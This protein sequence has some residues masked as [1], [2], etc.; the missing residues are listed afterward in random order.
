MHHVLFFSTSKHSSSDGD[1][2]SWLAD[3]VDDFAFL[4]ALGAPYWLHQDHTAE[5]RCQ[6]DSN[7]ETKNLKHSN[8]FQTLRRRAADKQLDVNIVPADRRRK[9]ILITD[10][11]STIITSESL[12]N[13]AALANLGNTVTTVTKR[14]M[15]GKIDFESALLERVSMLAGKSSRLFVQS[16]STATLISGA[17]ELVH[18]MRANG[19]K[20]YL[21]SGGF[22]VIT[23]PVAKLCGFHDHQANHMHVRDG[24]I[25]GTVQTPVLDR[26]AKAT[27]LVHYCKQN[28]ID[29]IDAATI[30]DGAN[31]LAM[32][33]A[34]GMDVAFEGKPL[35]LAK[36][37]I[38]LHHTDLR[39]LLY[40]QGYK[41]RDFIAGKI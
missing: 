11:D 8:A 4:H 24:K 10:M 16:I 1:A 30:G 2:A 15:A 33:Q 22:D 32:L 9:K 35:L 34:A 39:G 17:L 36:V 25:L 21:V 23:G 12:D 18:T 14:A 27:Y 7:F 19:A 28:G 3:L 38:Q 6:P 20:C 40:L 13:L 26:N 37:A 29:P 31:D 41:Q 5:L